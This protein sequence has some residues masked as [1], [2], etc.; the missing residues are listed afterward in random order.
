MSQETRYEFRN[1]N[2]YYL[3]FCLYTKRDIFEHKIQPWTVS[4][5]IIFELHLPILWPVSWR[6]FLL[7]DPLCLKLGPRYFIGGKYRSLEILLQSESLIFLK[8]SSGTSVGTLVYSC[9]LSADTIVVSISVAHLTI[10]LT[11]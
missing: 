1:C 6:S 7:N 9:I 5:G 11:A 4:C 3:F 8:W 10:I 2:F